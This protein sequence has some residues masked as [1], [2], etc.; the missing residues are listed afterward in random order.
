MA[1][2]LEGL[3]LRTRIAAALAL[4]SAGTA[5]VILLGTLWIVNSLIDKADRR[6]LRGHCDALRTLLQQEARQATV[7]SA[8]VASMPAVQQAMMSRDRAA[9]MNLFGNGLDD[10][11]TGYGV[12]QFQFH[13]APAT[14]FLRVHLPAKFGDDLSGFRQTVVEANA[15]N[16][17]VFGL[18]GGVAGLGIRGVAPIDLAGKQL[19]TVEFGLSFGQ[20]FFNRFKEMRH[21]D[22]AFHLRAQEEFKTFGGTMDETSLF[23]GA[24]YRTATAGDFLSAPAP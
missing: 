2:V 22:I 19:G 16:K 10:L 14:S 6:E 3:H 11:K 9:L 4:A 17:A 23:N 1:N 21:V 20:A 18:E 15:T 13:V 5:I 12:E 7:M 8:L 24:E